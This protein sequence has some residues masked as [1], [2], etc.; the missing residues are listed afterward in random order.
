MAD[1]YEV[2]FR[3]V[4]PRLVSLGVLRTGR[5]EL[6][7][8]LAQ[9]TMLRAHDRWSDVAGYEDPAAWCHRV[10][11]N[12]LID[13]HRRLVSEQRAVE[14]LG[15]RRDEPTGST[16][17][18]ATPALDRWSELVGELS[19]RQRLVV[20]LY[21]ADDWS[22]NEIA[23]VVGTSRGAVK[24]TLFKARRRLRAAL[25]AEGSMEGVGDGG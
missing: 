20:T 8:E 4:F 5:V 16:D 15:L 22:V 1:D 24:A 11:V 21:Y 17:A 2:L 10:M 3:S 19:E 9:E 7:T 12:L 6:A 18:T 25:V 14:R 13:H 23:S